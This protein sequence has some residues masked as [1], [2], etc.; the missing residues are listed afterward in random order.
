MTP[1]SLP[2]RGA[3]Q[4]P[5]PRYQTTAAWLAFLLGWAGVHAFYL[6]RHDGWLPLGFSA[7]VLGYAALQ[8]GPIHHQAV[9][10]LWQL[11]LLA[12]FVQAGV[13]ALRSSAR[14]DARYNPG[15]GIVN[16][17]RWTLLP[18]VAASLLIGTGVL[19]LHMLLLFVA[20]SEGALRY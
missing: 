19:K 10:Y 17:P 16:V 3:P 11:P 1:H 9:Y 18:V 4:H 13:L 12:G 6:R 20:V 14:F 7:A 8:P 5:S 15:L 2:T